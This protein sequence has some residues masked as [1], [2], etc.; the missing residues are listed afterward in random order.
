MQVNYEVG[1]VDLN[2]DIQD[3]S[4]SFVLDSLFWAAEWILGV[5]ISNPCEVK[6]IIITC[7]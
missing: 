6:Q 1:I 4:E 3:F 2:A 5:D 7:S